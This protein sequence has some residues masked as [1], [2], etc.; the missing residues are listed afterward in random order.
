M[1]IIRP[2]HERLQFFHIDRQYIRTATILLRLQADITLIRRQVHLMFCVVFRGIALVLAGNVA[3]HSALGAIGQEKLR[4]RFGLVEHFPQGAVRIEAVRGAEA[5]LG[6]C[7]ERGVGAVGSRAN[8]LR[9][10]FPAAGAGVEGDVRDATGKA[11]GYAG[12][13]DWGAFFGSGGTARGGAWL[14][15]AGLG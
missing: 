5:L 4:Q 12:A 9:D 10:L 8:A 7:V 14:T 11:V 13:V 15:Q 2:V 1:L 3:R 6:K